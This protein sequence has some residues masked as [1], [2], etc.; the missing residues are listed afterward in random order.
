M[1]R[2]IIPEEALWTSNT[3]LRELCLWESQVDDEG[4][5]A[6][7]DALRGSSKLARK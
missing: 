6:L 5:R 4:V 7:A 1:Y 3:S 2:I